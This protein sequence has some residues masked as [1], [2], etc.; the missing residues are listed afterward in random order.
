MKKNTLLLI[1]IIIIGTLFT[2]R[3]ADAATVLGVGSTGSEVRTVQ[4]E[5]KTLG[6]S[7]GTVDGIFGQATRSAVISFQ[8]NHGLTADG[9]VGPATSQA[10]QY[11]VQRQNRTYGI[12]A[13]AKSLIGVPYLWGGT[14]PVGFDCSG[15]TGYVYA[16][17]GITL[18]RSSSAQYS[19]GTPVA[20]SSL[21]PGDLVFF[22]LDGSGRV[23]HV[24]IYIGGGQFTS[25]T[26]GK[27]VATYSFISY[28][29]NAYVGAKRVY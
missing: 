9:L 4:T 13:T 24:G 10:L 6:Y 12:L 5:L 2:A 29:K 25:A 14:T 23:T 20:Y 1:S 8:S 28:W 7:V 19:I 26:S 16:R 21:R 18:P 11:S 22:S 17:H 3:A 15:F 27:G